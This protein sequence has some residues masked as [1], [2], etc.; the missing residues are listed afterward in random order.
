MFTRRS[1]D[2]ILCVIGIKSLDIRQLDGS[3]GWAI[4]YRTYTLGHMVIFPSVAAAA[5]VKLAK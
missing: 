4:W 5:A 3:T 2:L 1:E